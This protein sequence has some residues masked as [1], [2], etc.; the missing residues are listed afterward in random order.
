MLLLPA[1]FINPKE[2][3]AESDHLHAQLCQAL[4]AR[5]HISTSL[6]L[7]LARPLHVIAGS[8][9]PAHLPLGSLYLLVDELHGLVV[10]RGHQ[11]RLVG[12]G[13]RETER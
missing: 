9:V 4:P 12:F 6:A 8:E 11:Q 3:T 7:L 10:S 13:L 5:L 2:G 1:R